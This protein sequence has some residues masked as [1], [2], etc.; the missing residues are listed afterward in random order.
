ML[1][2]VNTPLGQLP[3]AKRA[4]VSLVAEQGMAYKDQAHTLDIPIGSVM[5]KLSR[6]RSTLYNLIKPDFK[7]E[8]V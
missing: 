2:K 4:N 6:A 7:K 8:Q 1:K 5:S 3:E